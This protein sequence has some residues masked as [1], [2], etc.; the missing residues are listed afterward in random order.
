MKKDDRFINQLFKFS[1]KEFKKNYNSREDQLNWIF[2]EKKTKRCPSNI[3]WKCGTDKIF[4]S[5]AAGIAQKL[6]VKYGRENVTVYSASKTPAY[7]HSEKNLQVREINYKLDGF[8][9]KSNC[10]QKRFMED[11][12]KI[13]LDLPI[14]SSHILLRSISHTTAEP[15]IYPPSWF[16]KKAENQQNLSKEKHHRL[17]PTRW[18][19]YD[20]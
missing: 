4:C 5:K 9:A 8:N 10:Q 13:F 3:S 20:E 11:Q 16:F 6:A 2:Y 18:I 7:R 19:K 1:R 12:I 17:I 14:T 15:S